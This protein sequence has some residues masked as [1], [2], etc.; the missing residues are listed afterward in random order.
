[1]ERRDI[2]LLIIQEYKRR[3]W[4]AD[5]KHECTRGSRT[6]KVFRM[7]IKNLSVRYTQLI[8]GLEDIELQFG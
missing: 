8:F 6:L 3:L 2:L 1:M 7:S 4:A 5:L